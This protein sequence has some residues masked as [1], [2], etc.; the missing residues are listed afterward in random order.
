MIRRA[1]RSRTP[2]FSSHVLHRA[3]IATIAVL[4]GAARLSAAAE[5]VQFGIDV[6]KSGNFALLR[7]AN[8]AVI[9]NHSGIDATG[10]SIVDLLDAA[11]GVRLVCVLSP[12]HGFRGTAEAGAWIADGRDPS[13]GV[14]IYSLYAKENRPTS[15]MLEGVDTIVFD[16]QDIGTRFYTY[17]ATLGMSLEE[18]ARRK[19]RFVVLD[20]PNPIRG[21][22]ME[23]DILDPDIRRMTGY[24]QIPTRHGMTVGEIAH[25]MNETQHLGADLTVVR[26]SGW[27]RGLWYDQT[28][29]PFVPPS[30]NIRSVEGALLYAGIGGFEATNVAVGRG[31]PQPFSLFGAPWIDGD[32]LAEHLNKAR[33]PGV[34]FFPAVFVPEK[35][36]YAGEECRGVRIFVRNRDAIRPFDIFVR[37]LLYL[38]ERYPSEFKPDWSEVRVVSGTA[39]LQAAAF[40]RISLK[41]L[42]RMY[43]TSH[44]RFEVEISPYLLY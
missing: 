6:L 35:H 3:I 40:G 23:G 10:A 18:A 17:I 5:P 11:P 24:F 44:D 12:E 30:P 16:I 26:M 39:A 13:T 19:L 27:R 8:V 34:S 22:I 4:W 37:A 36:I 1:I 43:E 14:P 7:G 33:L 25:W 9:T 42:E 21:D 41:Q 29:R 28:G 38:W 2:R 32:A 20:R 15:A 31:T